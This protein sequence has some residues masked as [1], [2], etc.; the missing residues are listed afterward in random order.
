[1]QLLIV[2]LWHSQKA[3]GVLWS[4]PGLECHLSRSNNLRNG[5]AFK[6]KSVYLHSIFS[7]PLNKSPQKSPLSSKTIGLDWVTGR[8]FANQCWPSFIPTDHSKQQGSKSECDCHLKPITHPPS[9][10]P[11]QAKVA[12]VT[13]LNKWSFRYFGLGTIHDSAL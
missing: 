4:G 8:N 9:L 5:K 13:K 12:K 6:I 11:H 1:M 2:S 10:K 7:V 3:Q